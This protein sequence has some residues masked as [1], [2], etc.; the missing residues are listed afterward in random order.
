MASTRVTSLLAA[1]SFLVSALV[2]LASIVFSAFS[3]AATP[4][5]T[6]VVNV[7]TATFKSEGKLLSVSATSAVNT[8]ALTP[9]TINL[10]GVVSA[11]H[12]GSQPLALNSSA[13]QVVANGVA[14]WQTQSSLQSVFA[15]PINTPAQINT[16]VSSTFS[17]RDVM[18]VAVAD[19]DQ[20]RDSLIVERVT[21]E[22]GST[23]DREVL[24]LSETGPST[25]YFVGWIQLTRQSPMS[26]DCRLSVVVNDS[27]SA[28]Y[29]D[30]Q[31]RT[32]L[33]SGSALVD[34][35]G[36][37]FDS[38]TGV[39]VNGAIVTLYDVSTGQPATVYGDDGFAAY[40]S[41][42][43]TGRDVTDGAG[44]LYS[45]GAGR[46][47]FPLVAP[48][49]YRLN[50]V[51]PDGYTFPSVFSETA[52]PKSN[53]PTYN[54]VIGAKGEP[55]PVPIG[56]AVRLDIPID[57][58]LGRLLISKTSHRVQA[59]VGDFVRYEIVVREIGEPSSIFGVKV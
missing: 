38:Q 1:P 26:N 27:I 19:A 23:N 46:Y 25:G 50:V 56:P 24:Q 52:I 13:C 41:T 40:P 21:V 43:Q 51:P 3:F 49:V 37:V 35:Y 22:V 57:P 4:P 15:G 5:N 14:T 36:I 16:V 58:R 30:A 42:Y 44:V 12:F 11:Q 32:D 53:G 47:R 54:V 45:L 2:L 6:P 10:L 33:V 17:G 29:I 31:D 9:A 48:G 28:T 8:S 7:A 20:N 39:P 55:F 59:A 18:M 34:P